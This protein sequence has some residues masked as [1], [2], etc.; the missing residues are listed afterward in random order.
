MTVRASRVEDSLGRCRR[1]CA[2][3][4]MALETEEG[5]SYLQKIVVYGAVRMMA[6]GAVLH[7]F[8]MFEHGRRCLVG[9][10]SSAGVLD[11]QLY[12]LV[13]SG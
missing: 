7:V 13:V 10:A 4:G 2:V 11:G 8:G 1:R 12:E 3:Y 6:I 5:L 9:M